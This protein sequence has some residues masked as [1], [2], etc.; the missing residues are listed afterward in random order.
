MPTLKE[1]LII[2]DAVVL[3][4]S[5]K[6]ALRKHE[7]YEFHFAT[8]T[9]AEGAITWL[10]SVNFDHVLCD[11]N[12]DQG[13]GRDVYNWLKENNPSQ[14]AKFTFVCGMPSECRGLD[15]PI[16]SKAD[17]YLNDYIFERIQETCS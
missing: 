10:N 12:L 1:I 14:L 16:L 3:A 8:A 2:E 5:Y 15:A 11:Y 13:T 9:T 7:D 4:D 17:T 6:R